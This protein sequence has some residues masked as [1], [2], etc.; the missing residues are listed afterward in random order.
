MSENR[1]AASNPKRRTGCNVTSAAHSGLKHRS[2]KPPA[3]S[4]TARYSGKYRPACRIIQTGGTACRCL[5]STRSSGFV[6]RASVL[7]ASSIK[8]L[9]S[10]FVVVTVR[11]IGLMPSG[12]HSVHCM[13]SAN[14]ESGLIP[15]EFIHS[16]TVDSIGFW[17][18]I[19]TRPQAAVHMRVSNP[20][21]AAASLPRPVMLMEN[22]LIAHVSLRSG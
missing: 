11:W 19:P 9:I 5:P 20:N 10:F 8:T 17:R 12:Q 14:S 3:F 7:P 15:C 6:P 2:R 4:R 13:A 22:E 1:I 18:P 16:S 21:R